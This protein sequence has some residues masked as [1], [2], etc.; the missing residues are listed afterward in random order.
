MPPYVFYISYLALECGYPEELHYKL[1][2]RK[3]KILMFFKQFVD[4]RNVFKELLKALDKA[5]VDSNKKIKIQKDAQVIFI[6]ESQNFVK[7]NSLCIIISLIFNFQQTL[8][9]FEKAPSVYN[10]PNVIMKPVTDLP[11]L[12]DKNKKYPA[13]SN[14]VLFKYE[15]GRGRF[16]TGNFSVLYCKN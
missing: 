13:L 10:D 7:W 9:F 1:L 14:A 12:P 16:A 5:K 6:Y 11:K 3:G 2:E 8:K 15:P 4:A